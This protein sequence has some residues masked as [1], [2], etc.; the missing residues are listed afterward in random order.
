MG[1]PSESSLTAITCKSSVVQLIGLNTKTSPAPKN[2]PLAK[3][4]A[5]VSP[6]RQIHIP[7]VAVVDV[8]FIA[9]FLLY[10]GY[11]ATGI[12]NTEKMV[13]IL[14]ALATFYYKSSFNF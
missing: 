6:A 4:N 5:A 8:F 14:I 13:L 2:I 9:P 12:N 10:V 3:L 1:I 7:S 11:K